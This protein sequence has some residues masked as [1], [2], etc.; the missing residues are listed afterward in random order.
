MKSKSTFHLEDLKRL[1]RHARSYLHG[2]KTGEVFIKG[3]NIS[4]LDAGEGEVVLLIHGYSSTKTLWRM[5]MTPLMK[6]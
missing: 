5:Q 4:Y 6:H 1:T 2:I 3:E